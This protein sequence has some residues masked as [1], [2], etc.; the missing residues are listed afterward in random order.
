MYSPFSAFNSDTT[1]LTK[2]G[3]GWV[4]RGEAGGAGRCLGEERRGRDGARYSLTKRG[5]EDGGSRFLF[6]FSLAAMFLRL[7]LFLS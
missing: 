5:R 2:A 4:G 7:L 3:Q 1:R 6:L